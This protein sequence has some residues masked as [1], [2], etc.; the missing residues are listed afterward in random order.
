MKE[1]Q[2]DL[3]K[4]VADHGRRE[5]QLYQ[6]GDLVLITNNAES[7]PSKGFSK[8]FA[9][10][11]IGP[12]KIKRV[13]SATTYE[14]EDNEGRIRGKYYNSLITLYGGESQAITAKIRGSPK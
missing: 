12:F 5:S 14:V 6:A 3:R 4:E 11:R 10:R 8:K 2:Q 13:L 9:P 7:Q 1:H